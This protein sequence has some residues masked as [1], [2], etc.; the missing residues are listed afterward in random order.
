MQFGLNEHHFNF[1]HQPTNI[2]FGGGL[3]DAWENIKTGKLHIV[4]Y[5]STANLA[6]DPKPVNL[7]GNW[8]GAYKRQM[9]M[10]Q[11]V[12]AWFVL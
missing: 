4:D 1:V 6:A 5:K 11:W 2:L 10:Y 8:K 3:D 9:D 7:E 12:L